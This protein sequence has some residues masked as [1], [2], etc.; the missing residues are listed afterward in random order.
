[1]KNIKTLKKNYEFKKVFQKGKVFT[2][3]NIKIFISK[4][5]TEE[6]RIG[7]AISVKADNA[8]NRNRV[9]RLIRENYRLMSSKLR[10]GYNIIFLWN[11]NS[12]IEKMNFKIIQEDFLKLFKKSNMFI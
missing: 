4:N 2:S 7:I 9:K 3:E 1:M 10:K 5:N 6:N 12:D 8:V 11:K